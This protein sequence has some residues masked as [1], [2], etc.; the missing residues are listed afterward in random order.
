MVMVFSDPCAK[1]W[2]QCTERHLELMR[3]TLGLSPERLI[4]TPSAM[5]EPTQLDHSHALRSTGFLHTHLDP[6]PAT[7]PPSFT[8]SAHLRPP[9][10]PGLRRVPACYRGSDRGVGRA[11]RV[12]PL[13][14]SFNQTAPRRNQRLAEAIS[15]GHRRIVHLFG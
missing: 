1:N 7:L 14:K 2:R 12:R 10:S 15:E 4:H 3:G 9:I 6:S 5:Q 11:L 13:R 8:H